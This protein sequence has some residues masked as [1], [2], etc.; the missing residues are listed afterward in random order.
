MRVLLCPVILFSV[1]LADAQ[2]HTEP[3]VRQIPS[4]LEGRERNAAELYEQVVPTVVTIFTSQQVFTKV[5]EEAQRGMGSG[6]LIS[7][8]GHVLTA[9][10]VVDGSDV[11][12]VKMH[13]GSMH[14]AELLFS[15]GSA[16]IALL[17][18]KAPAPDLPH[19]AL[20]D[21]DLLAVGQAVYV[22]GAPYGL[23]NSY[24]LGN[25]SGF[26]EFNRLYDGTI[27]AEFIQTDAAIN[28]GNSGGPMFNSKGEVIGIS[29]RILTESGGF[30]GLGFVVTINT[31]KQLLAL[32]EPCVDG[33]RLH[34]SRSRPPRDLSQPG[35][36]G[37][38]ARPARRPRKPGGQSRDSRRDR[39]CR[40]RGAR[41]SARR[42]S[43]TRD[44]GPRGLPC[45]VPGSIRV[46]D[47]PTRPYPRQ[48][49]ARRQADGGRSRRLRDAPKLSRRKLAAKAS[50][51]GLKEHLGTSQRPARF[52]FWARSE[53]FC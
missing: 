2:E 46:S 34:L 48:A 45:R 25:I 19:A 14:E 29:S 28:S 5:G 33:P 52:S 23:E 17:L 18:L 21:S 26:R 47:P 38:F 37:R 53:A 36:R 35:L 40:N 50:S 41:A 22:I 11:I 30:Q 32:E 12:V 51:I 13:D 42:R 6:V 43:D 24:S 9:A 39:T 49:I 20:G 44:G 3:K 27:L 15:E 31:A 1:A 10:H 7:S 8:D 4:Y 16:D